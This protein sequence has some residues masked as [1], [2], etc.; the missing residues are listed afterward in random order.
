ML[1]TIA[2]VLCPLLAPAPASGCVEKV[3][4]D[5]NANEQLTMQSCSINEGAIAEWIGKHPI[6]RSGWRLA[7]WKCV[8]GPYTPPREA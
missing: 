8:I 4:T 7:R 1:I 3:I 6:Y 2:V 5:S